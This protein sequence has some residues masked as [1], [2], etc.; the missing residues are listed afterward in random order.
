MQS[1]HY[2]MSGTTALGCIESGGAFWT[3]N[4]FLLTKLSLPF[5][6]P[7]KTKQTPSKGSR[8]QAQGEEGG[9]S[10]SSLLSSLSFSGFN[11]TNINP[12]LG[13]R[14]DELLGS[15]D[16]RLALTLRLSPSSPTSGQSSESRPVLYEPGS[17]GVRIVRTRGSDTDMYMCVCKGGLHSLIISLD[18]PPRN[19]SRSS[20]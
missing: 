4:V 3:D 13:A 10:S 1:F 16:K 9:C 19:I 15:N 8:S 20:Y 7:G 11:G 17:T 5:K 2:L 12:S 14:E 18:I 6:G